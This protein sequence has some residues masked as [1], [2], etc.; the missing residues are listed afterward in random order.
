MLPPEFME[1]GRQFK[2][3]QALPENSLT[4]GREAWKDAY[5]RIYGLLD[6]L[7]AGEQDIVEMALKGVDKRMKQTINKSRYIKKINKVKKVIDFSTGEQIVDFVSYRAKKLFGNRL[8]NIIK[9]STGKTMSQHIDIA[10]RKTISSLEAEV[11]GKVYGKV[12]KKA[13]KTAIV[14]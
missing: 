10:K 11:E 1:L 14:L 13:I 12:I 4:F 8:D 3:I 5:N 2:A 7:P 9:E 6:K